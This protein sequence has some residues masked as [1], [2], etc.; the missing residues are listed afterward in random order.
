MDLS[1]NINIV[2][3]PLVRGC[4]LPSLQKRHSTP[5]QPK[6]SVCFL[7][8][9]TQFG[10]SL[11]FFLHLIGS[12]ECISMGR[13]VP[14]GP[15]RVRASMKPRTTA[16]LRAVP[17]SSRAYLSK[18]RRTGPKHHVKMPGC[19][20]VWEVGSRYKVRGKSREIFQKG[21]TL[22]LF[23]FH[24]CHSLCSRLN[25]R[26]VWMQ[27]YLRCLSLNSPSQHMALNPLLQLR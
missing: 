23:W 16:D 24:G 18:Q 21:N 17:N 3:L 15:P 12:C 19:V 7:R 26:Y 14:P 8:N 25:K 10:R 4:I 11:L 22:S 5:L 9:Q 2:N 20:C 6:N 27:N 13:G 1:C